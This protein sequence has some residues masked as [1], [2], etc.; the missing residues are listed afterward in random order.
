MKPMSNTIEVKVAVVVWIEDGKVKW[1]TY[2]AQYY[3]DGVEAMEDA[4]VDIAPESVV[5]RFFLVANRKVK[6]IE[7]VEGKCVDDAQP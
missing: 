6:A 1:H 7:E 4:M 3:D 5:D 2:G